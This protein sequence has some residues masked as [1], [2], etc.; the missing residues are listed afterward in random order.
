[1]MK[2]MTRTARGQGGFTLIELLVVVAII[3]VLAAIAVPQ[4]QNYVERS[5]ASAGYSTIRSLQT[6]YDAAIFS[7]DTITAVTDLGMQSG[8]SSL[9]TVAANVTDADTGAGTLTFTFDGESVLPANSTVT[10]TRDADGVWTCTTANIPEQAIP[11]NCS[12]PTL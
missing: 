1:M 6:P 5:E 11:N 10:L 2:T 4:Y 8:A 9:G 12:D 3:G 7:S